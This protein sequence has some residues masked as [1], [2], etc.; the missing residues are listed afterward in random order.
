MVTMGHMLRQT[1]KKAQ[2][3]L[4]YPGSTEDVV[5]EELMIP[6]KFASVVVAFTEDGGISGGSS[7][8][9]ATVDDEELH[10]P[11]H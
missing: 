6:T 3:S 8:A 4:K 7:S 1:L 10:K 5:E 9:S 11:G 2:E